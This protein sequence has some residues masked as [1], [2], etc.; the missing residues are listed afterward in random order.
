MPELAEVEY[1]RRQWDCGMGEKIRAVQVH[2]NR[3]YRGSNVALLQDTL[4]GALPR[5]SETHGKQMVFRFSKNA[6]LGLHMGMTGALRVES[7]DYKPQKHDHLVLRQAVRSLVFTDPRQ[8]GRV[9]FYAGKGQPEWWAD[10]PVSVLSKEFTL[11]HMRDFL[12]RHGKAP[13]KAV[14][15]SQ[16]GFP[17]VGNWMADEIL[18]QSKIN[19]SRKP[20]TLSTADVRKLHASVRLVCSE[21]MRLVAKD[22]GDLPKNWLFNY[23]WKRGGKCPRCHAPLKHATIGGR[24]TCW[25]PRDQKLRSG[26]V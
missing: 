1:Y 8:F 5:E 2:P 3:I 10:L 22:W 25:C 23:R 20:N 16:V 6:W 15:L 7:A 12:T 4:T 19:P 24:T 18:W 26:E 21:A 13:L 9:R 17:G 11:E 14:L